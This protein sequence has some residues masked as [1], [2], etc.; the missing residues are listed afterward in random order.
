MPAYAALLR[1]ASTVVWGFE[2]SNTY[3]LVMGRFVLGTFLNA[4]S[5]SSQLS[6]THVF[7]AIWMK[8]AD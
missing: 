2:S 6:L 8:R 3:L 5:N 1:I 7:L 4:F